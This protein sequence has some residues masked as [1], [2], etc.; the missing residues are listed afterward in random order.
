[1]ARPA[2]TSGRLRSLLARAGMVLA[3]L[4]AGLATVVVER[5]PE[6]LE[7]RMLTPGWMPQQ[8]ARLVEFANDVQ[9]ALIADRA[10]AEHDSIALVLIR[11]STLE[12]LPYVSPIDRALLAR[13]VKAVDALGA[14]VIALDVL[15]DAPT[16]PAKDR[17]LEVALAG[18]KAAVVLGGI[19]ERVKLTPR[20]RAWQRDFLARTGRPAGYFNLRYDSQESS[21]NPIIRIRAGAAPGSS[22]QLSFAEAI[23]RAAGSSPAGSSQRIAWLGAP[24]GGGETFLKIDAD[25][26]LATA[27][28]PAGVLALAFRRQLAGKVVVIGADLPD[29]DRHPTP[30]T[31]L[32]DTGMA[33]VEVHAHIAAALIDGR[34][35]DE[36]GP[37]M[38]PALMFTSAALGFLIGWSTA[39]RRWM[40]T[41]ASALGLLTVG[42]IA[43]VLLW[44]LRSIV[45][46]TGMAALFLTGAL[47]AR[48]VRRSTR[49]GELRRSSEVRYVNE[50]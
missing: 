15:L 11:E 10:P 23:A 21:G 6:N 27:D 22:F 26:L 1:M 16:E 30:L 50:E 18:A 42:G 31:L 33:G 37:P 14:R 28:D 45:P 32:D 2:D 17:E 19:D 29:R 48:F 44:Q 5:V 12:N 3:V 38:R 20:R 49:T 25:A 35:L 9:V 40:F 13:L 7:I 8:I 43:A 34:R 36:V 24:R 41:A 46:V 47:L 39:Q 4:F